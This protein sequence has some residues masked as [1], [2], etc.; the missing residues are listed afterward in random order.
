MSFW[1]KVVNIGTNETRHETYPYTQPITLVVKGNS[2]DIA[3]NTSEAN[4][5]IEVI[6]ACHGVNATTQLADTQ[7]RYDSEQHRLEVISPDAKWML[8]TSVDLTINAPAYA[9]INATTAAGDKTLMPRR[10]LSNVI[11]RLV[12]SLCTG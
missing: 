7:I 2:G 4:T 3:V 12:I 11:P 5:H 1:Q 8:L 9:T 6:L 10:R